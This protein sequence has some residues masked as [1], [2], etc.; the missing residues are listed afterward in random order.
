MN[1][2]YIAPSLEI[3]EL[4][5]VNIIATSDIKK[6]VGDG[7]HFADSKSFDFEDDAEEEEF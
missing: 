3:T 5:A 1:K 4:D 7:S 2:K 6:G